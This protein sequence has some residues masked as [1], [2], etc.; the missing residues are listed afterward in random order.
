MSSI[1][2]GILR[3]GKVPPDK[4]VP[5]TPGQCLI[6]QKEFP[7]VE[8][9]VQSSEVRAFKDEEYSSLGLEVVKDVSN[10]DILIGV[11]E[12]PI[13]ELIPSKK[14]MF[15]SHTFKEQPYNSKLLSAILEKKIQLIDYEVLTD[16]NEHRIIGFGR[17][18]GIVGCYN[19]LLAFGKKHGAY[20]IKAANQ[21]EN[22]LE[23]DN[24]LNKIKL[25]PDTKIVIT[26]GGRVGRGA[27]E[28]LSSIGIKE[29]SASDFLNQNF[30]E[31][32]YTQLKVSDYFARS[33]GKP[34]DKQAFYETGGGHISMF[35][36]FA[37]VADLYIACHY[38]DS[39]SPFIIS[40]KDLKSPEIKLSVVADISCDIDG[41][42]A[43][44]LR[45][46]TINKPHYGYDPQTESEV[47]F[48]KE[49]AIGVMAVDNL[50]CEL[51]KDAS[52]D[53]GNEMIKKVF[54]FLF[55]DDPD[56]II[57]RASETDLNGKLMPDY[58][59]LADY[60]GLIDK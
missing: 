40:R 36:R 9:L 17:Y 11:K 37:K 4:R 52:E 15:F 25:L 26:G 21:C 8:V 13:D 19:G 16:K 24:E 32:V 22:R 31:A 46:S 55:G 6:V 14:Y 42:I 60:V 43:C 12:V 20:T 51:P 44:T 10:C 28:I 38:W 56:K 58:S 35:N 7:R 53:F 50:P 2:I 47:D 54:P 29:V 39:S 33:D 27:L 59:Y 45:P 5:L 41:P 1:K 30:D 49:G 18:A 57:E 3:E 48:L 34:F 23:L